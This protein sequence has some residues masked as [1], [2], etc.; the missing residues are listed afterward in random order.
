MW[1]F[2]DLSYRLDFLDCGYSTM[3]P[4]TAHENTDSPTWSSDSGGGN[5][6]ANEE[7]NQRPT[8]NTFFAPTLAPMASATAYRD[9][10]PMGAEGKTDEEEEG[11][12]I[13]ET[14]D[15]EEE[16]DTF[17]WKLSMAT[18]MKKKRRIFR[19]SA[20]TT[21]TSFCLASMTNGRFC[22]NTKCT[23]K[24]HQVKI[25]A[26][27]HGQIGWYFR[28]DTASPRQRSM[29]VYHAQAKGYQSDE[30]REAA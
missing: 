17:R 9:T 6:P 4:P 28:D 15:K 26:G 12:T 16:K 30:E 25:G 19:S 21:A 11:V 8:N 13:G 29:G 18:A 14:L 1:K 27:K 24:I 7:A 5:T 20:I 3:A 10:N 23:S 22:G 2:S